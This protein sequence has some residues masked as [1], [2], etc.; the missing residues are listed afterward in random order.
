[1]PVNTDKIQAN[2]TAPF[3]LR[4]VSSSKLT[5]RDQYNSWKEPGD[6]KLLLEYGKN[7][8]KSSAAVAGDFN[9]H[10]TLL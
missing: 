5:A 2:E 10:E 4:H 9:V 7:F 1:M 8:T 6:F 3:S